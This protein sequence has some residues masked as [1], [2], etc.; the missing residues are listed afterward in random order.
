[1]TNLG[2]CPMGRWL[3][4]IIQ[5]RWRHVCLLVF[6]SKYTGPAASPL[7]IFCVHR[8][9]G[10]IYPSCTDMHTTF[11]STSISKSNST[12]QRRSAKSREAS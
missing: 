6:G 1:M 2:H 3:I 5:L 7:G 9:G 12:D 8:H 11:C 10:S 4:P